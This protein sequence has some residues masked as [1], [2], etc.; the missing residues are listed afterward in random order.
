MEL[1]AQQ[2]IT[3]FVNPLDLWLQILGVTL[4]IIAYWVYKKFCKTS[5][6]RV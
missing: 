2:Q 5:G 6:R 1:Q 3:L 4:F